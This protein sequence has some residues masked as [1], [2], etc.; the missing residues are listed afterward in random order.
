MT[1]L[2][3]NLL[4]SGNMRQMQNCSD[5]YYSS[6]S[7]ISNNSSLHK[8]IIF[9]EVINSAEIDCIMIHLWLLCLGH[10]YKFRFLASS[11]YLRHTGQLICSSK[12]LH[13][14]EC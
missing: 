3:K 10:C 6:V 14:V 5:I 12:P 4:K 7:F 1:L 2:P 13:A 9:I 8:N 11:I